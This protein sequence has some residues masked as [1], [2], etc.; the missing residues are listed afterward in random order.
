MIEKA[1]AAI[2]RGDLLSAYDLARH[3]VTHGAA[4]ELSYIATL[5]MA[6]MGET[7][8]ALRL[9]E[10]CKLSA[11]DDV[12]SRALGARLL[13]DD[14]LQGRGCEE[15]LKR[16]A[17][18]YADIYAVSQDPFPAINAATLNLLAGD[19]ERA[20]SFAHAALSAP[21]VGAPVDYYGAAT[22][23]EALAV[24]GR[25]S[26]AAEAIELALALPGADVGARSTTLRQF[27]RLSS[28]LGSAGDLQALIDLLTPPAVVTFSGHIFKPDP[29]QEARIAAAIDEQLEACNI[30]FGYGA[31]AGGADILIAERLLAR[32]STL[33]LVLPFKEEDFIAHSVLPAGLP[34]LKRYHAVRKKA[35]RISFATRSDFVHDP[36]QFGY[37]ATV[38]M[39]LAKLRAQHLGTRAV[40]LVIWDGTPGNGLAGTGHDVAQWRATGGQ[41]FVIASEGLD[42]SI[43]YGEAKDPPPDRHL[44]AFLFA[45]FPGFTRIS[46]ARLPLFWSRVMAVAGSVLARFG[47][48]VNFAN[49]WGDAVFAVFDT[50]EIA[51]HAGLALQT[52]LLGIAP[53]ELGL[54]SP[55]QMRV[56]L[57][58]GPVYF[59]KDPISGRTTFYGTE[60]SRAARVEP[61]TPPGSVYA[62]E[63]ISAI[64]AM[65]AP[66]EFSATYVGQIGLPKGF[67]QYPLYALRRA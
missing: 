4:N 24:L 56:S 33:N 44:K 46:E 48:G 38:M 54:S 2:G 32:G 5:A 6:R 52:E 39:G 31:L 1:R 27:K 60:V 64:L 17:Q 49:S 30:G 9:Y 19:R 55:T 51:A 65:T 14:A 21:S 22:K 25:G 28:H 43:E 42:R 35:A 41:T 59:G 57:H 15:A 63:P 66:D 67:G 34:W 26:E 7:G 3:E 47:E 16:A 53:S 11:A 8:Q 36:A 61:L 20:R 45:D 10:Q 62:S 18:A 23:A 37:G 58:Y 40:Q 12:D 13:K 29:A 50:A